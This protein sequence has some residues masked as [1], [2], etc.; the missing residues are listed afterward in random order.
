[1]RFRIGLV[2]CLLLTSWVGVGCRKALAPNVDRNQAPETWITAAPQDT[3]TIKNPNGTPVPGSGEPKTIPFKFHVYWAGSDPDGDIAGFYYAVVETLPYSPLGVGGPPSLPG[4]KARD[5]RFTTRTDSTFIFNVSDYSPDREHAFYIYAVDNNGKADPTPARVVFNAQDR[6]PPQPMFLLARGIGPVWIRTLGGGVTQVTRT[7]PLTDTARV[8]TVVRDSLPASARLDFQWTSNLRAVGNPAVNYRYKLDE[9]DFI[10][11]DSSVHAITYNSGVNDAVGPGLKIFTLRAVDQAGGKDDAKRRFQFNQ[12]PDTWFSGPMIDPAVYPLQD[13]FGYRYFDAT[14]YFASTSPPRMPE[15]TGL[16]SRDSVY[17]MPALRPER[18]TFF[19]IYENRVYV[20]AEW[21][22]VN[23][24][25]WVVCHNGGLDPDS[26]YLVQINPS[27]PAY[28]KNILNVYGE[29]PP[30]MTQGVSNGSPVGFRSGLAVSLFPTNQ[31]SLYTE[32]GL[33]P[34]FDPTNVRRLAQTAQYWPV[35]LAGQAF[36]YAR[37]EDGHG[38]SVGGLD[39]QLNRNNLADIVAACGRD[40]LGGSDSLRALRRK[41]LTFYVDHAPR[42]E[43]SSS[44]F[45]PVAGAVYTSRSID[46]NL[47]SSDADPYN[48]VLALKP[49][50]R[51]TGVSRYRVW[52]HGL[53]TAGRDTLFIDYA[54]PPYRT[55]PT[56]SLILPSWMVGPSITFEIEVCDCLEC[57]SVAGSGRCQDHYFI[58]ATLNVAAP[59]DGASSAIPLDEPGP[60]SI[61]VRRS[62]EE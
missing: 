5:Y 6:Y 34:I 29:V 45:K 58:P 2:L 39:D 43:Q 9:T 53:N 15:L 62:T 18:K 55:S 27:D 51:T 38:R 12:A 32:T 25:A 26:P 56:F 30:V 59:A 41:I 4:P 44:G 13:A 22:T 28:I 16:F 49:G 7:Y 47:I 10:E 35:S 50:G 8:G 20:H 24:N 36:M 42:L 37:A 1:M 23:M 21:D 17:L 52:V 19:E 61:Q 46:M 57:E 11:V 54:L 40:G 14:T 48:P 33:Y 60:G 31:V 3:V